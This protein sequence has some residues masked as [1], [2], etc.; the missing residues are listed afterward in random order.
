[1]LGIADEA[2]AD[3]AVD[4]GLDAEFADVDDHGG[5]AGDG[6][7]EGGH[8]GFAGLEVVFVEPDVE[9]VAAEEFGEL[10]GGLGVGTG[11]A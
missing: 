3:F 7:F 5:G 2:E 1:M 8:P 6:V 11:V 9:V 4:P 10:A